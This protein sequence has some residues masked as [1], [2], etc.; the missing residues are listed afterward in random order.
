MYRREIILEVDITFLTKANK[1][2]SFNH[3]HNL[4]KTSSFDLSQ[5]LSKENGTTKTFITL[6]EF[7]PMFVRLPR[8][9]LAYEMKTTNG[10]PINRAACRLI[11]GS[12]LPSINQPDNNSTLYDKL[13]N[14]T[15]ENADT[16]SNTTTDGDDLLETLSEAVLEQKKIEK[17]LND[18]IVG[19][20]KTLDAQRQEYWSIQCEGDGESGVSYNEDN[21][22][23]Y[24]ISAQVSLG[25]IFGAS[26]GAVG[27]IR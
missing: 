15:D 25:Q 7:L 21:F 6:P 18:K 12:P 26:V 20:K 14:K 2:F 8:E 10:E 23:I 24:G 19:L 16:K 5:V 13:K 3:K 1:Q 9:G 22:H 27:I 17:N 4:S 11:L